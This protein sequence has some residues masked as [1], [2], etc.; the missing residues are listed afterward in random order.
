MRPS[1]TEALIALTRRGPVH[2]IFLLIGL[3]WLAP[4]VGL[5]ITSFRTRVQ[6]IIGTLTVEVFGQPIAL[7][8]VGAVTVHA[9][10]SYDF[11]PAEGYAGAFVSDIESKTGPLRAEFQLQGYES[12]QG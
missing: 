7:D 3:I 11:K 8:G 5:A 4:S 9:D 1:R 2:A 12:I 10:G 6:Q